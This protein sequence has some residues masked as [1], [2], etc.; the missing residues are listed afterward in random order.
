LDIIAD[1]MKREFKVQ[2]N[3]GAPQIAYRET[4]LKSGKGEGKLI[5]QSGGRGQYGHCFLRVTPKNRGEGYEFHDEIKGGA[6]P[7]EFINPVQKGVEEAM[8]NGVL[9]GYQMVDFDVAVYDGTY[10]DVDS[11]EIAFKIAAS[12]ALQSAVKK[13][14]LTLLEPIMKLEVSTPEEFLGDV[15]GNLSS[16][17]AQILGQNQR[18]NVRIITA[19]VP[20][21][22]MGA[23]A[24]N[25][26]SMTQGRASFVLLP[27]HYDE[28]PKNII[29]QIVEERGKK[30]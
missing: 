2:T 20:L 28:V 27:S 15:I 16:K 10:H 3:A 19:H 25:L 24:T 9:A 12:M 11:S 22:E 18:K 26:R 21:A 13:A 30:S 7:R 8:A 23:Y 4:I 29:E 1:R 14:D 17:R 5:K 6:I